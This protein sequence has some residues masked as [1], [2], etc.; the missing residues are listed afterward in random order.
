MWTG[1]ELKKH[2]GVCQERK[3]FPASL[4]FIRP[5]SQHARVPVYK[6]DR[7]GLEVVKRSAQQ[8]ELERVQRD[9]ELGCPRAPD[10][11]VL[12]NRAVATARHVA[13]DSIE[14]KLR[15]PFR[16]RPQSDHGV[17]Q[18]HQLPRALGGEVH[19]AWSC[20]GMTSSAAAKRIY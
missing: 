17:M 3:S 18:S 1:K 13:Y 20:C 19:A 7:T 12:P 4:P 14:Q 15:I 8:L 6:R 9:G 2:Y 16:T 10:L 5:A 11:W